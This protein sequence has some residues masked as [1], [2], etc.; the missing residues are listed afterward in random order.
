MSV[1]DRGTIT[2]ISPQME[3]TCK[4]SNRVII[5]GLR[6]RLVFFQVSMLGVMDFIESV[7]N[8]KH[9]YI[10]SASVNGCRNRHLGCYL[11]ASVSESTVDGTVPTIVG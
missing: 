1:P 3:N 10:A 5:I 7:E 4:K 11:F 9:I 6:K 2:P 8:S